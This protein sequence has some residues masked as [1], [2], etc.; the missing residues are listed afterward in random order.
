MSRSV[1]GV[2]GRDRGLGSGIMGRYVETLDLESWL[3]IEAWD[4]E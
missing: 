4:L 2:M 1:S 3:E